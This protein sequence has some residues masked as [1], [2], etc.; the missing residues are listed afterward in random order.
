MID[1]AGHDLAIEYL[2]G[3][4]ESEAL[5][6]FEAWMQ[7]DAELRRL[8]DDLRESLAAVAHTAPPIAPPPGLRARVLAIAGSEEVPLLQALAPAPRPRPVWLPWALAAGFAVTTGFIYADRNRWL[9]EAGRA[10][11]EITRAQTAAQKAEDNATS[12]AE[13]LLVYETQ[14]RS[15]GE[16]VAELRDEITQLRGRDALAQVKIASLGS[17]VAEFAKAGVIVVWDPQDQRGVIK[18][19]NLQ[20]AGA[21]KDYQLWVID[22]KY[23]APVNGGVLPVEPNG[24]AKLI[25]RPDQ[26]I[27]SVDK[28]AISV[29]QA[30][31]VPLAKGPI[32]FVGD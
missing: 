20:Q 17:Q 31:G 27:T 30:G 11:N 6:E 15:Q 4:L 32:V 28:F 13:R 26:P 19:A 3:G 29:E 1:D 22:P 8:V 5:R 12:F 18:L 21:G 2:L 7:S 10:K 9:A 14:A 25:F 23:P 16:L 24:T